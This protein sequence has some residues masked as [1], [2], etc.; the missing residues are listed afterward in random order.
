M[1]TKNIGEKHAMPCRAQGKDDGSRSID[2]YRIFDSCRQQDCLEDLQILLPE[3][4]QRMVDNAATVRVKSVRIPWAGIETEEMSFHRGY[5]RVNVRYFFHCVLECSNGIGTGQETAGLAVYDRSIMLYGGT[6]RVASF[7]SDLT[8]GGIRSSQA[9]PN[10]ILDVAEPVALRLT[11]VDYERSRAFGTCFCDCANLP[12][13][14][15]NEFSGGFAD[16]IPG[17]KVLFVTLGL[18]S[19]VRIERPTQIIVPACDSSIPTGCGDYQFDD[20]DPCTL[21]RSMEFPFSEFYPET[22]PETERE[23]IPP[24]E[25]EPEERRGE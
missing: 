16:A 5:Y 17:N 7:R 20:T 13:E 23:P 24:A 15:T 25:S 1:I 19:M 18:F 22:S 14:I 10:I 11:T 12:E 8:R 4:G 9:S 2:T 3:D 6:S 21:F